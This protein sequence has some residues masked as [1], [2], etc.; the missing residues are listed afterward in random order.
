MNSL[1]KSSSPQMITLL[2]TNNK[3]FFFLFIGST[4]GIIYV[5]LKYIIQKTDISPII[6][7]ALFLV[8][9]SSFLFGVYYWSI[10]LTKS[11]LFL[12]GSVSMLVGSGFL[13]VF[14]LN[15]NQIFMDFG[16]IGIVIGIFALFYFTLLLLGKKIDKESEYD[17][18]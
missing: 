15:K 5:I 11:Q 13:F 6:F 18:E 2:K 9:T 17:Y 1:S 3:K 12:L 8:S 4:I 14:I 16:I 10:N 7:S